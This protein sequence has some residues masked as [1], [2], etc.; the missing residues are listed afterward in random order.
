MNL[1]TQALYKYGRQIPKVIH[2]SPGKVN[3]ALQGSLGQYTRTHVVGGSQ[4]DLSSVSQDAVSHHLHSSPI[5]AND[6]FRLATASSCSS[7]TISYRSGR[8]AFFKRKPEIVRLYLC[9]LEPIQ[10]TYAGARPG[11]D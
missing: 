10:F 7:R 6:A 1:D 4:E 2:Q 9:R 11:N 8:S 3:I 5:R